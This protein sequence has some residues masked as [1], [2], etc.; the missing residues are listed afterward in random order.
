VKQSKRKNSFPAETEI[1]KV[2]DGL[3]VFVRYSVIVAGGL[4]AISSLTL[5]VCSLP[6]D[7]STG[8]RYSVLFPVSLTSLLPRNIYCSDG[9]WLYCC[10]TLAGT[11]VCIKTSELLE[12]KM[13]PT[14]INRIAFSCEK[15]DGIETT[16]DV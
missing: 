5:I 3:P 16:D 8:P 14:L 7:Q 2:A 10:K 13:R 1:R 15:V 11:A 6:P 4:L 9:V 12:Y